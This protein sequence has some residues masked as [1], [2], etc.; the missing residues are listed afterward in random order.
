MCKHIHAVASSNRNEVDPKNLIDRS[1]FVDGILPS[2]IE[3]GSSK[4]LNSEVSKI[5][6]EMSSMMQSVTTVQQTSLILKGFSK[7]RAELK[8]L[9]SNSN[10]T[11]S[12]Q[13]GQNSS[14]K[15]RKIVAQRRL[16]SNKKKFTK[17]KSSDRPTISEA[18]S[19]R[20]DLVQSLL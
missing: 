5:W 16:V 8:A 20:N 14:G 4:N 1:Q 11:C 6:S 2:V 3:P 12:N 19:I 18:E 7:I 13:V 9:S 10:S 15:R 17:K